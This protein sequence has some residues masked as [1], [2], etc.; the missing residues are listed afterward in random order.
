MKTHNT[1]SVL[2][3]NLRA[4][5]AEFQNKQRMSRTL[6]LCWKCQKDKPL[7]GGALKFFGTVRRFI[8][9]NCV[10]AK[11]AAIAAAKGEA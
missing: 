9:L 5:N 7:K 1:F 11:V 10:E 4:T 6:Q 2:R 3:E 8:C